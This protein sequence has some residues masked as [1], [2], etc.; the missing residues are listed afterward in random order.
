MF[1]FIQ[2]SRLNDPE[3]WLEAATQIFYSMGLGFG[4]ILAKAENCCLQVLWSF[5]E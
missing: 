4:G 2:L 5:C 3:V 1:K